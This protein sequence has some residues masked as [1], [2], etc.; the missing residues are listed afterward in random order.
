MTP[1]VRREAQEIMAWKECY[2]E[3]NQKETKEK[4]LQVKELSGRQIINSMTPSSLRST[5][6]GLLQSV[7]ATVLNY[8]TNTLTC[9]VSC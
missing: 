3:E 4:Q 2:I 9:F 7:M 1:H 8:T 5:V 6:C